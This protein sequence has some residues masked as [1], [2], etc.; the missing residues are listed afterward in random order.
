[1][2]S[3][4]FLDG[5]SFR[6]LLR[7][8]AKNVG[9][10]T[11]GQQCWENQV[12]AAPRISKNI[13]P[14]GGAWHPLAAARWENQARCRASGNEASPAF[15]QRELLWL[16]IALWFHRRLGKLN[17]PKLFD[18]SEPVPGF[19]VAEGDLIPTFLERLRLCIRVFG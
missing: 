9:G 14:T 6:R 12:G 5:E 8:R 4:T 2:P 13:A 10:G 3:P 18:S 1:M 15:H 11:H 7:V 16:N 17:E 19:E